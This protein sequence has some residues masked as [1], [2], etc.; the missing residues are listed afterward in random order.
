MIGKFI[1]GSNHTA[2]RS[3]VKNEIGFL[4]ICY[5]FEGRLGLIF[6]NQDRYNIVRDLI[7][8]PG[9]HLINSIAF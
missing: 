8:N 7:A 1:F 4:M 9:N 3:Q 5:L 6:S 2:E